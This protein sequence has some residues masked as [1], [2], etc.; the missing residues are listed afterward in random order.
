MNMRVL[1]IATCV[2]LALLPG[3]VALVGNEAEVDVGP[4]SAI[5]VCQF[6]VLVRAVII[7]GL[8]DG[9]GLAAAPAAQGLAPVLAQA[10]PTTVY[11]A[12][13]DVTLGT[14]RIVVPAGEAT[15]AGSHVSGPPW[16]GSPASFGNSASLTVAPGGAAAIC[17]HFLLIDSVVIM[18]GAFGL[19]AGAS[20]GPLLVPSE[21]RSADCRTEIGEVEII[22]TPRA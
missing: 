21:E 18:G 6:A 19:P 3:A 1:P 8:E 17:Q 13:C 20:K 12:S 16:V 15:R 4:T 2:A 14:I 5:A 7:L 9:L 10:E 22:E 11:T